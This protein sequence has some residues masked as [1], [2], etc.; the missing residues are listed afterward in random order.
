[1]ISRQ[2]LNL[3]LLSFLCLC[4][5]H[6]F[7][8][9]HRIPILNENIIDLLGYIIFF[10]IICINSQSGKVNFDLSN[11][12]NII[13]TFTVLII[14]LL[15][16]SLVSFIFHNQNPFTSIL[17]SRYFFYFSVFIALLIIK[18]SQIYIERLIVFL[19]IIYSFVFLIQF[20][21]FPTEIVP[22]GRITDKENGLLRVRVE[23]AGFVTLLGFLS[24]NRYL[25]TN[26][27]IHLLLYI[28]CLI[29][30]FLLGFRTLLLAFLLT[31]LLFTLFIIRPNLKSLIKL[32]VLSTLVILL[33]QTEIFKSFVDN[34]TT[35]TKNQFSNIHDDIRYETFNFLYHDV[36]TNL[37][38]IILG[39]GRPNEKTEYGQMVLYYG[40]EIKG[41][42]AA[43][44]G[45]IGFSFYYG[46]LFT[47]L[48]IYLYVYNLKVKTTKPFIYTKAFIFY[49]LICSFSTAEIFREGMFGLHAIV[50]YI[51]YLNKKE[52]KH[53]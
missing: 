42:I 35:K 21:I 1:M 34:A 7:G 15:L 52:A 28:L 26:K 4:S 20:M 45:L 13:I 19:A 50:F 29:L 16:S 49:L 5:V 17:A 46:I 24:L 6:F 8:L 10:S 41:H 14:L 47:C 33:S 18:P 38:T 39:N 12:K 11:N 25:L 23:G 32:T 30:I 22:L 48:F 40:A 3:L 9:Y 2:S 53:T 31:S 36:N 44:L 51:I 43:D 37:L 27:I